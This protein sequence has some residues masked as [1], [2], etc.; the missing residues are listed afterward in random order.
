MSRVARL[1]VSLSLL[2]FRMPRAA[3]LACTGLLA[4]SLA[5]AN[6]GLE[7]RMDWTYLFYPSDK[8]VRSGLAFRESFPLPGD[9]AVLVDHGT[10]E[11]R[12]VFVDRLAERLSAEPE[13]FHHILHRFDLLPLAPKALYYL[14]EGQLRQM[15]LAL[16]GLKR[17]EGGGIPKGAG[18]EILL[19]LLTDLDQALETRGRAAYVPIWETLMHDQEGSAANYLRYLLEDERWVY[20]VLGNGRVQV[21]AAKA[22]TFGQEF[23]DASPMVLRLRQILEDL[24]PSAGDLRIRLTGLP[25][26][27][28]DERETVSGDGARSTLVSLVLVILVFAVG[29]GEIK[30]PALAVIALGFGMAWTMGFATVAIGH[31]NFISVTLATMLMG[32]GID[33]GIHFIFRYDEE[34]GLG[35]SPEQA[36]SRTL[37]GTGVDTLVGA[38]GTATAFLALTQ[39]HFRGITDFGVIAAGGTLLCFLSTITVLPALLSIF[40]GR[41]RKTSGPSP[42]VRWLENTLLANSGKVVLAWV[43]LVGVACF[44]ATRVGFSYNLLEVQAQEVS[45]V[46]TE[47]EMIRER[48]TVLSAE[49]LA[50]SIEQARVRLKE[51]EALPSVASVG[52]VVP[53]LP[54]VS[55]DKQKLIERIVGSLREVQLPERVQLDTADDLIAVGQRVKEMESSYPQSAG[56]PEVEKVVSALREDIKAMD[57]GPIQDGLSSFQERLRED[58]AQTLRLLK[59][60]KAEPPVMEDIPAELRLRYVSRDGS[61]RQ[62]I[63][64]VKNIWQQEN[65]EEFLGELKG[66]DPTVMGHPVIQ[67]AIL[68]AFARTLARTPWFTLAGV[69]LVFSLYLKRPRAV[70]LSLLPASLAVLMIFASMGFLGVEF[71]VVNFV[72]LPISVGLGAV[73]GV[74]AMHRMRELGDETV[75]TT[76][77]GPA[78]LLSGVTDIVGFASLMIAAHR[79]ISSLGLVIS[80][81]VGV[82]F[83]ASLILLPALRRVFRTYRQG[84]QSKRNWTGWT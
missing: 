38:A 17:G 79:G 48:N 24:T 31:L 80:V 66:V 76:S 21:V 12:R 2:C 5:A 54:E 32:V 64:P 9:V 27:L 20:P 22:G 51:F 14:D 72:G 67:E 47:I 11:Q 8:I 71:N 75:L 44:Y 50:A 78:L 26:M 82:S 42:T 30:R 56:D 6:A 49:A 25:V 13:T 68:S 23:V 1:L 52:S 18:K 81:G 19:K 73:Y 62:N 59:Q 41:V 60:Q 39:A 69:L 61:I 77:T 65:L 4:V 74:H 3:L 40:P 57:P 84:E 43:V 37:E 45:T 10:P 7:L 58:L 36:I 63:Q 29:F 16:E 34:M 35:L 55:S 83:M 33:F 15:L 46:R 70:A 53:L 28:H